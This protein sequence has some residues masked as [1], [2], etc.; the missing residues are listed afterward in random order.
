M[1][2]I[3]IIR[4]NELGNWTAY[5]FLMMVLLPVPMAVLFIIGHELANLWIFKNLTAKLLWRCSWITVV[6]SLAFL[7]VMPYGGLIVAAPVMMTPIISGMACA[8]REEGKARSLIP[9]VTAILLTP[10]FMFG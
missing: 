1:E 9:V 5:Q 4:K 6:G 8:A 3:W 2:N 7:F 10:L